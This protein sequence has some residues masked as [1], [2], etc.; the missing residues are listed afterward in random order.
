[1]LAVAVQMADKGVANARLEVRA[2]GDVNAEI[3]A[4]WGGPSAHD[5]WPEKEIE[6]SSSKSRMRLAHRAASHMREH[7]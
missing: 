6:G 1:M 4:S 7:Q 5:Y 3:C 2:K